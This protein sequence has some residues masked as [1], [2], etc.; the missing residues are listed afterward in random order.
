M[1]ILHIIVFT[2]SKNSLEWEYVGVV[3]EYINLVGEN[4]DNLPT[5]VIQNCHIQASTTGNRSKDSKKFEKD[6]Q[7]LHQGIQDEP[8]NDRYYFY[9]AQSYKDNNDP[10]MLLNITTSE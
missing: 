8:D 3:H 1:V 2:L 7:L 5:G 10:L 4:K 9:L 6:I